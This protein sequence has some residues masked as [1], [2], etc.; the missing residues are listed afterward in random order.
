MKTDTM[1]SPVKV[2]VHMPAYNHERYIGEAIESV[3]AQEVD[4]AYEIVIG[5]DRS[6]D[7]TLEVARAFARARPGVVR[8]LAHEKN[9]GIWENDQS[10]IAACRGE[11]I[12]WLE[13]DDFWTR[14]D[15][16]RRLVEY[17]D[18][19][20]DA[21]ACFH[22]AGCLS[23]TTP[24]ITWRGS[25]PVVKE[26]YGV[27]DLLLEGHF[28]PSCTAV[29]RAQHVRP[30]LGWTRGTPFLEVAYA[31]RFALAGKIGF[32]DE[33]MAM[34]RYHS[35][36]VYGQARDIGSLQH[37]LHAHELVG[38]GFGLQHLKAY[39]RG[40][41]RRYAAIARYRRTQGEGIGA[42]RDYAKALWH[43]L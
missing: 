13:A 32:I 11:Y 16:L 5:E 9:L 15:K 38:R 4:F 35:K 31:L 19:H 7:N 43:H 27:D 12:A 18:L 24:P 10:I 39:R 41:A 36:G 29:F 25:P 42:A 6:T 26:A 22:R 33:E 37:A 1:D 8:V 17:M 34:F 28:I 3:L 14:P 20:S 30:A 40:L 21:S 2:S 23:D